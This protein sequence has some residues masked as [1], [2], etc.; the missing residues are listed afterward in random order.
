MPETFTR[1]PSTAA[2]SHRP[3]QEEAER[4]ARQQISQV[5]GTVDPHSTLDRRVHSWIEKSHVE[6]YHI[7]AGRVERQNEVR[8]TT[9]YTTT[10][11]RFLSKRNRP[12]K[13]ILV[14]PV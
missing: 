6:L 13:R 3:Q 4:G 8:A 7:V 11:M 14:I 2:R 9:Y 10:T 5:R 1:L 12:M